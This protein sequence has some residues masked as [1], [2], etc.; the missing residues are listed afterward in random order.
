LLELL[1]ETLNGRGE[2]MKITKVY[3][4]SPTKNRKS[5]LQNG[6]LVLTDS[7]E[8]ENPLTGKKEMWHQPYICTSLDPWTALCYCVPGFDENK[9]PNLDLYEVRLIDSDTIRIRNDASIRIIEAR[10]SNSIPPDR[11]Q[12]IATRKGN[13][14]E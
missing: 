13:Y 11:V 12:W 1:G 5:I 3:H 6:L 4:W 9:L 14:G 2:S 7:F 8:Y 10:I